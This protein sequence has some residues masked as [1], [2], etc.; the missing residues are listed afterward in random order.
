MNDFKT[1]SGIIFISAGMNKNMGRDPTLLF[2]HYTTSRYTYR[3]G[4]PKLLI[5]DPQKN[6]TP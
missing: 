1:H 4:Q 5:Q 6:Q 3:L 2:S